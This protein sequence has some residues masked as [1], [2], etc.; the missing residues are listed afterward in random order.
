MKGD[1][2]MSSK[3]ITNH[4]RDSTSSHRPSVRSLTIHE[5]R[6]IHVL[7][8]ITFAGE[9][10]G[11]NSGTSRNGIQGQGKAMMKESIKLAGRFHEVGLRWDRKRR[12]MG[13]HLRGVWEGVEGLG[14]DEKG[15]VM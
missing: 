13:T 9:G 7:L 12:V 6:Q 4:H 14:E 11:K 5:A 3:A 2:L 10:K 1:V 8:Q 15:R